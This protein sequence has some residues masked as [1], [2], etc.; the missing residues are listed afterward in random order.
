MKRS[1]ANNCREKGLRFIVGESIDHG[2]I[3]IFSEIT[4]WQPLYNLYTTSEAII[5]HIELPGVAL[6]NTA[7]FL[8]RR[9]MIIAGNRTPPPD[10]AEERCIFHTFEIPF[11]AFY[12]R[13]DFPIPVEAE[14]YRYEVTDGILKIECKTLQE[15]I[16]PVEGD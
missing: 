6:Q 9:H 4:G 12:R 2:D 14:Q 8:H 13:I 5:V 16:I 10:I 7:V 11:G 1:A 15:K 3:G